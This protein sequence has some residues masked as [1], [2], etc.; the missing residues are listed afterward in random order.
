ISM[1]GAGLFFYGAIQKN[2]QADGPCT[3]SIATIE[4]QPHSTDFTAR[5]NLASRPALMRQRASI[6]GD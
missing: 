5:T 6:H 3:E 2:Q 4:T 1:T